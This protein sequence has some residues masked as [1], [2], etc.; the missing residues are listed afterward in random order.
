MED[1][2]REGLRS[3]FIIYSSVLIL[4]L[5]EDALRGLKI[6]KPRKLCWSLNPCSNGRCSASFEDFVSAYKNAEVLILV[7]MEDALRDIRMCSL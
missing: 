7:L 4:V 6:K 1:A 2:L 3:L 5:M